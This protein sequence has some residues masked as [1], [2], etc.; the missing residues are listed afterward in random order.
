[1]SATRH[2]VDV[3]PPSVWVRLRK[4]VVYFL[5][6]A[7]IQTAEVFC[8][9]ANLW[10]CVVL[11]WPG[12]TDAVL[13]SGL[14]SLMAVEGWLAASLVVAG[15]MFAALAVAAFDPETKRVGAARRLALQ[16]YFVYYLV[17]ALGIGATN[18]KSTGFGVYSLFALSA[19]WGYL[20]LGPRARR[21]AAG[22]R[23]DG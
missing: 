18:P 6:E 23:R 4:S 20:R 17:I 7:D 9:G 3:A 8:A 14:N 21:E 2:H 1:M 13:A 12:S 19:G 10:W 22:S 5:L 16:A 15:L 11:L